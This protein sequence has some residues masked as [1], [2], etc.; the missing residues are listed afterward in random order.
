[1]LRHLLLFADISDA[2]ENVDGPILLIVHSSMDKLRTGTFDAGFPCA[3]LYAAVWTGLSR[4][5]Y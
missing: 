2:I 5:S 1:M 4:S 3:E